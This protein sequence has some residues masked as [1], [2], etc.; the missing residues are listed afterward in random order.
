MANPN[1]YKMYTELGAHY[2]VERGSRS[3][4]EWNDAVKKA[5]GG[6][7]E[8]IEVLYTRWKNPPKVIEAT[9]TVVPTPA[10]PPV[11]PRAPVQQIARASEAVVVHVHTPPAT[12]AAEPSAS[13]G[14]LTLYH[15]ASVLPQMASWL[16]TAT[17]GFLIGVLASRP[18]LK[19]MGF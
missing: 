15:R 5:A 3:V 8:S 17:I 1:P 10:T 16:Q 18:V 14:G 19:V 7:K 6:E 2:G 11:A 9:A 13:M 12:S 4:K